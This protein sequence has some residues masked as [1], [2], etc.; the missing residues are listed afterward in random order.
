[1]DSIIE[2]IGIFFHKDE[3]HNAEEFEDYIW[4][5]PWE[6]VTIDIAPKKYS[7]MCFQCL[8]KVAEKD[9][10]GETFN[11]DTLS[12][13]KFT[14]DCFALKMGRVIPLCSTDLE[15]GIEYEIANTGV[16]E[17]F[18]GFEQDLL[19]AFKKEM[20]KE[21]AIIGD[22]AFQPLVSKQGKQISQPLLSKQKEQI[23][24]LTAWSYKTHKYQKREFWIYEYDDDFD[25]EWNFEGAINI[26]KLSNILTK[27]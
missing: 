12:N 14:E 23:R 7:K 5:K 13:V 22:F 27:L 17:V 6:D 2:F 24:I 19:S 18:K 16:K 26:E 3:V 11:P 4:E 15:S 21:V 10:D 20:T 25:S 8:G 1:M 9:F